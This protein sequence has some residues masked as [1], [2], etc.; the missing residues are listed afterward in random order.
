MLKNIIVLLLGVFACSTAAIMIRASSLHPILLSAYRLLFSSVA[1]SPLF[2]KNL[3][4]NRCDYG[5]RELR[6]SIL[7][8]IMLGLHF[9]VWLFAVHM[10]GVANATL[11]VNLV[12]IAM[13]FALF[14]MMSERLNFPE[15]IGT[16]I[17]LVGLYILVF[18]DLAIDRGQFAGD[19]LCLVAMILL[20]IYLAL[21]RKNRRVVSIWLYVVP[22]YLFGGIFCMAIAPF[23]ESP[24]R[25][26]PPREIALIAGL[27][28]IP[29]V[30][31]HSVLN[32]SMKKMRGQ[33]VSIVNLSQFVFAGFLGYI[34]FAE[35]PELKFYPASVLL[36][37]GAVLAIHGMKKA[38]SKLP[39][40]HESPA[41]N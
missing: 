8:G 39:V 28:L 19:M 6:L 4:A 23:F 9:I 17:A 34:F 21:G 36:I 27:V 12:P 10:T 37:S 33:F 2:F 11:L 7:P 16:L 3:R 35:V 13:P 31:G 29:T 15:I 24:L 22:L 32:H 26:Y 30:V 20:T 25:P 1:L 40:K 41:A 14:F 38:G 5:W 18:N